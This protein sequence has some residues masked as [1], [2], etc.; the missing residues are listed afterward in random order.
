MRQ[1]AAYQTFE[2]FSNPPAEALARR[3]A[4]IAPVAG[5]QGVLHA[6]RR[7]RRHRH[8][9]QARAG[10]LARGG[11]AGQAGDR[12]PVA[13]LPRGE[14]LRHV[15]GRDSRQHRAVRA[16]GLAGRARAVGRRDGAGEAHRAGGR[17][18]GRRVLLR[19]GD[20]RRA[21]C[22]RRRRGTWS[23]CREICRAQRRAVR[24]RRGDHRVRQ[25]R[26][27]VR[28]RA[29][30]AR[31]RHDHRGQGADVGLRAA[32]RGDRRRPGRGAV[33]A[34]RDRPRCS[35]T[36]TPTQAT[37]PRARSAWPTWTSSSA[38]G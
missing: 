30:R 28:Q 6:G 10:L 11:P 16:A 4:E 27:L 24:G 9:G 14:R 22:T 38:R 3:V 13:R 32:R 1:L 21:A 35:G 37:P 5:R 33:L 15:P 18:A 2:P 8:R 29:V 34:R 31:S 17:R 36:A 26:R 23:G 20:R 12:L 7:I 25:A 19:A